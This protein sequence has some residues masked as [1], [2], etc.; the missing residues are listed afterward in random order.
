MQ[1]YSLPAI[2]QADK[3]TINM[4]KLPQLTGSLK[5]SIFDT[6][7]VRITRSIYFNRSLLL[8]SF[9]LDSLTRIQKIVATL[10]HFCRLTKKRLQLVFLRLLY[11]ASLRLK[12]VLN[13]TVHP[14]RIWIV[15]NFFSIQISLF[16]FYVL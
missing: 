6:R 5:C 2:Q 3:N 14:F 8:A 1:N 13:K 7:K 16:T 15:R 11:F 10:C 12:F 4:K 9:F